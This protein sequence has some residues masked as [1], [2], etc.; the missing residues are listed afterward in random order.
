M[1]VVCGV[2]GIVLDFMQLASDYVLDYFT[3][4]NQLI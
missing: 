4:T 2:K 3:S 1:A